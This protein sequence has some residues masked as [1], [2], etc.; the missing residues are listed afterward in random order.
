MLCCTL[1]LAKHVRPAHISF[2][3]CHA[4]LLETWLAA[5]RE[6]AGTSAFVV[7]L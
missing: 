7:E 5:F 2:S 4:G 3:V 6:C 1:A